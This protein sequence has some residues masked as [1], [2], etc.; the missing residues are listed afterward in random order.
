MKYII[1]LTTIFLLTFQ[2]FGQNFKY[3]TVDVLNVRGNAGKEYNVVGKVKK[4]EKVTAISEANS[5]TQIENESGVKGY[6]STKF[7]TSD[8]TQ[9]K[10]NL[11]EPEVIG[12]KYG[13]YKAFKNLF[14]FALLIF[15]GIEYYKSKKIKDG[16]FKTGFKELPFTSFELIKY[17]IYSSVV[18]SVVGIFMGIFYWIK[19]F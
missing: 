1:T 15:A 4:G 8:S 18:C 9:V 17:A 10:S 2:V 16:R 19:S 14:I 7:L 11:K 5:W 12:F 6:V 3:V 13:F